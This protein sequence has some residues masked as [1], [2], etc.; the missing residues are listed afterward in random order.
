MP[1]PTVGFLS[2]FDVVLPSIWCFSLYVP[3]YLLL[4][5]LLAADSINPLIQ[6]HKHGYC[7]LFLDCTEYTYG[8][9]PISFKEFEALK[10]QSLELLAAVLSAVGKHHIPVRKERG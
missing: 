9:R 6:K 2:R 8:T 7:R 3:R 1:L 4:F 10:N 5:P